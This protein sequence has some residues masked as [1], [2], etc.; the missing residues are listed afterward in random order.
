M[1]A[2]IQARPIFSKPSKMPC[3]SWS[4]E[5]IATC[6]ASKKPNGELVDACANCYA[7]KGFYRMKQVKTPRIHNRQDWK[8]DDWAVAMADHIINYDYFR[9]FDS[10]D[11]YHIL[12][13]QK[14]LR[15]MELT[16]NTKHWMPTRMHKFEKFIP[17]L[18]K[19]HSL[20][21]VVVRLSSDSING[22]IIA[23]DCTSTIIPSE[24]SAPINVKVCKAPDNKGKCGDCRNCW[25]KS[26]KTVGYIHH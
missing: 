24:S 4:L 15:V 20:P 23:G 18:D 25:D 12:L 26:V 3:P 10:G 17:I 13:A 6:P 16:P 22:G 14:I 8:S 9:W 21:N 19:M 11:C 1:G 2:L 5:A 7:T